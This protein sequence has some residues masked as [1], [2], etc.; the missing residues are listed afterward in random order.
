V[1]DGTPAQFTVTPIAGYA[2]AVGGTC[3]GTLAGTTYTTKMIIADCTV[4]ATFTAIPGSTQTRT[5][6]PPVVDSK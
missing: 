6:P 1:S 4:V 5:S 3:G 2:A